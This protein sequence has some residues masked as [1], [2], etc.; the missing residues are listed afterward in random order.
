M[1]PP[2]SSTVAPTN[3]HPYRACPGLPPECV[4]LL[5]LSRRPLLEDGSPQKP[6]EGS[7]LREIHIPRPASQEG[8]VIPCE[9]VRWIARDRCTWTLQSTLE[10]GTCP[11]NN[12]Y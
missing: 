4:G 1:Q 7:L 2:I 5:S 9:E 6:K 10:N 11:H 12:R 8:T 3:A